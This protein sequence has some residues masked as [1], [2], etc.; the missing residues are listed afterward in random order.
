MPYH[1][2]R[3]RYRP[4]FRYGRRFYR[5]HR[6]LRWS[7]LSPE[8]PASSSF[9][10]WAQSV[11]AQ[12]FGPVVPQNGVF[13]SETRAFV[14]QFQAQRGLPATGDLDG[15]T[16]A[17]LQAVEV[18]PELATPIPRRPEPRMP[19]GPRP[20]PGMPRGPHPEPGMPR[21]PRPEPPRGR[22]GDAGSPHLGGRDPSMSPA[23]E[24]A[25]APPGRAAGQLP[26]TPVSPA[27]QASPSEAPLNPRHGQPAGSSE[28]SELAPSSTEALKRGRWVRHHDRIV[29]IGA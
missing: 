10:A 8:G 14:A 18:G 3:H 4:W 15:A 22:Q 19:R 11:L 23:R 25:M 21:G 24:P 2:F 16:V 5:R 12:V 17:A 29:L 1:F 28:E 27:A 26:R 7:W 6:P 9:V 20:E 13:G